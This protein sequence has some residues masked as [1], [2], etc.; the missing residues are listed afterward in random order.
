LY[1]Y[2]GGIGKAT[3]LALARYGCS[4]AIHYNSNAESANAIVA[5]LSLL[6][7]GPSLPSLFFGLFHSNQLLVRTDTR[8]AAFQADLSTIPGLRGLH[9]DVVRDLGPIDILFVN[10][11]II[12]HQLGRGGNI[13]DLD[14]EVFETTWRANT[15]P[16]FLASLLSHFGMV[17]IYSQADNFS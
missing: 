6:S 17:L 1:A 7:P 14:Y 5:E 16:A 3:A 12:G 11:G 8:H 15:A 4:F 10:H 13:E 9:A 2:S